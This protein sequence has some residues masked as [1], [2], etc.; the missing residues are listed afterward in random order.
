MLNGISGNTVWILCQINK[1]LVIV[2][3]VVAF[4]R[5]RLETMT[6]WHLKF[7]RRCRIYLEWVD[8]EGR[9]T[10]SN[11]LKSILWNLPRTGYLKM[12]AG[13][14][15]HSGT[16]RF[17]TSRRRPTLHYSMLVCHMQRG[18]FYYYI[19]TTEALAFRKDI[20]NPL[21]KWMTTAHLLCYKL[22]IWKGHHELRKAN[23]ARQSKATVAGNLLFLQE[24]NSCLL[25]C[26]CSHTCLLHSAEVSS[27][28]QLANRRFIWDTWKEHEGVQTQ[29]RCF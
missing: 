9:A 25:P 24:V 29:K 10:N 11:I 22:I 2:H 4:F 28:N 8:Q 16:K 21:S 26:L 1:G 17:R 5:S 20:W 12:L 3:L 15:P 7:H 19:L 27:K 6:D 13:K 18:V 14:I 23:R